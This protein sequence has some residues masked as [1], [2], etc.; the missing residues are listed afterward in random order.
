MARAIVYQTAGAPAPAAGPPRAAAPAPGEGSPRPG[1]PA[2]PDGYA[3]KLVKY[4]PAETIALLAGVAAA[5]VGDWLRWVV[6][7]VGALGTML[8]VGRHGRPPWFFYPLSL[9]SFAGWVAGTTD[10]AQR[11][12][13]LSRGECQV[14]LALV[15]FVVPAI[16]EALSRRTH[17]AG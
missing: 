1:P 6:V 2:A 8:L 4:V 17:R 11:L 10:Y 9:M 15:V 7:V 16:D 13:D 5:D 3:E 12:L 14:A